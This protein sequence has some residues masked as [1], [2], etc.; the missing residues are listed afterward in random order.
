MPQAREDCRVL[1][2]VGPGAAIPEMHV[3]RAIGQL[4]EIDSLNES[5]VRNPW[6]MP[7]T[8]IA[9]SVSSGEKHL[10]TIVLISGSDDL[11]VLPLIRAPIHPPSLRLLNDVAKNRTLLLR[12]V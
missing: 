6:P 8:S 4:N 2:V 7:G 1:R 5:R 9:A 10:V 12:L 11:A 3:A